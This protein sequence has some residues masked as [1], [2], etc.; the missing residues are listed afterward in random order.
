MADRKNP[1]T[2]MGYP[3]YEGIHRMPAA[4]RDRATTH[5][6][7]RQRVVGSIFLDLHMMAILGIIKKGSPVKLSGAV[8]QNLEGAAEDVS[9]AAHCAPRQVIIG[10][11][12]PQKLL[13]KVFP[14]RAWALSVLFAETDILPANFNKCDSRA[15]RHGLSEGFRQG[16]QY[17][18]DAGHESLGRMEMKEIIVKMERAFGIYKQNGMTAFR[19]STER[20]KDKLKPKFLFPKERAKWTEQLQITEQYAE[21]LREAPGKADGVSMWK[22]EGSIKIYKMP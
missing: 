6:T 22:I 2:E 11:E 14:D 15:E 3:K 5:E 18:I 7:N 17:I 8:V 9:E 13:E 4:L 1:F 21:T 16:C 10:S 12:T 20:L 19:V